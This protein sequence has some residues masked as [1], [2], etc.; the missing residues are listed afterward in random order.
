MIGGT[1]QRKREKKHHSGGR[2]KRERCVLGL[3]K[4]QI[5][6]QNVMKTGRAESGFRTL[7]SRGGSLNGAYMWGKYWGGSNAR[8]KGKK[9]RHLWG[10]NGGGNR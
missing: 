8:K 9:N 7:F 2:K 3:K 10:E 6:A 1:G 5:R 4:K